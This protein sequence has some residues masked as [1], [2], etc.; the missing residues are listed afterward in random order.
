MRCECVRPRTLSRWL[1]PLEL[2]TAKTVVKQIC[3][4]DVQNTV[5][6]DLGVKMT[7][8]H[9]MPLALFRCFLAS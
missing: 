5:L 3:E 2:V 1:S 7:V 8:F 9:V 4:R 6:T